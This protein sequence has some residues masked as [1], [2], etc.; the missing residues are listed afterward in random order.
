MFA[1]QC[2]EESSG[3]ALKAQVALRFGVDLSTMKLLKLGRPLHGFSCFV[4]VQIRHSLQII[5]P[6]ERSQFTIAIV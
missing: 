2:D 1:L 5:R 3:S 6:Y 4:Y